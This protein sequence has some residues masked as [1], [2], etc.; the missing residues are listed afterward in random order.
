MAKLQLIG[1]INYESLE[2]SHYI[3]ERRS[4]RHITTCHCLIPDLVLSS[5]FLFC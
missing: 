5:Y 3:N 2:F 1:I 4:G